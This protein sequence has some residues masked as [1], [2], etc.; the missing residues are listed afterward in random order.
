MKCTHK[1]LFKAANSAIVIRIFQFLP[2]V[3]PAC[4]ARIAGKN[5]TFVRVT[6][7]NNPQ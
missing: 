1:M 7:E 6:R 5:E 4:N 2:F 3:Y